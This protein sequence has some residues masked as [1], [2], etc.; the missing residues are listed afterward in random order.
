M[1]RATNAL[2]ENVLLDVN[3]TKTVQTA[4]TVL[5]AI[6]TFHQVIICVIY[7]IVWHTL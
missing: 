2:L 6:V 7:F 4:K 1:D 5:M 3:K